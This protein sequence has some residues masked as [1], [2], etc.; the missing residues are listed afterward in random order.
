M[1]IV[2]RGFLTTHFFMKTPYIA[3]PPYPNLPNASTHLHSFCCFFALAECVDL[4]FL[5]LVTVIPAAPCC[6]L[7]G[8]KFTEGLTG[9][10]WFL[11]VLWFEITH[12]NTYRTQMDQYTDAQ[13]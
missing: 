10:T 6:M 9:M 7:Q 3:Y 13:L 2:G 12:A 5:S 11:L 4:N 8:R 1:I